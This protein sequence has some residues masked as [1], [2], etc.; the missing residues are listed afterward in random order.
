VEKIQEAYASQGI[1]LLMSHKKQGF[2]D[3]KVRIV[4][5]LSLL[6]VG[7]G[8]YLDAKENFFGY[9]EIPKFLTWKEFYN[10]TTQVRYNWEGSEFDAAYGSFYYEGRLREM[11]RIYSHKLNEKYLADLRSLYVEKIK[12]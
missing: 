11:I 2:Y 3:A 5:F 8:V 9:I 12:L 4:K 6:D 7:N 10:V 1:G